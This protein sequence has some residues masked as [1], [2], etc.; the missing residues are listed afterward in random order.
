VRALL[1]AGVLI[2]T[3]HPLAPTAWRA[4]LGLLALVALGLAIGLLLVPVGLL[5][6]DVEQGLALLVSF[7]MFATPVLY[8][9]PTSGSS[10]AMTLN[11]AAPLLD[12]TRSWLL[13]GSAA[14]GD[15]A[16]IVAGATMAVLFAGWMLYR[17]AMPILIERL[18]S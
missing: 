14:F 1:L 5:F 12:S 4:P 10:L 6:R 7:W 13:A 8:P 3:G 18:G 2:W 17:L 16:G 15:L 11:P 9:A